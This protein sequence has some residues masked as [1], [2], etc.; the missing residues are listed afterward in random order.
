MQ[1]PRNTL[2]PLLLLALLTA[3]SGCRASPETNNSPG[4]NTANENSGA[5]QRASPASSPEA[6]K[7]PGG[8]DPNVAPAAETVVTH[9]GFGKLKFGMT[10]AQASQ[11]LG[12][13]LVAPNGKGDE[14]YFVEPK[15]GFKGVDFMV[16]GG[17]IARVDIR[18]KAYATDKG[19]RIGDA[20]ARIKSLYQGVQSF[21][22]K[23]DEKK[24]D[25]EVHSRDKKHLIIFETDGKVV[26]GFRAGRAEEAGWAERCG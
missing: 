2:T 4:K 1:R 9:D 19:A 7:M 10:V 14:C 15:Q 23:Y 12:V 8:N 13:E 25:L 21:P 6:A 24:N 20:E 5:A 26:T 3:I 11:A 16:V 17:V 18:S 22:Q